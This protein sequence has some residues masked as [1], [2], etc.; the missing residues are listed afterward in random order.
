MQIHMTSPSSFFL[1]SKAAVG[2]LSAV[3]KGI[4]CHK[5]LRATVFIAASASSTKLICFGAFLFG[6]IGDSGRKIF[7]RYATKL[8]YIAVISSPEQ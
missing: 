7:E 3:S 8:S 5:G 6:A 2:S 1:P 4:G